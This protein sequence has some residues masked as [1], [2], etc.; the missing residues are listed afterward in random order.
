MSEDW[1]IEDGDS[2]CDD[3]LENHVEPQ[4]GCPNCGETKVDY[5]EILE[6]GECLVFCLTCQ[7]GYSLAEPDIDSRRENYYQAGILPPKPMV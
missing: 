6:A 2:V 7:E 3:G 1:I 4:F 5:L